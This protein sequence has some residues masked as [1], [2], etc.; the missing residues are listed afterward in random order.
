[1]L[2][3]MAIWAALCS[4]VGMAGEIVPA[5]LPAG[6]GVNIHFTDPRPGEMKMLAE[7]GFKFVR[8]DFDWIRTEKQKGVYDFSAYERLLAALDQHQIRALFILDY[9]SP[10]YDQN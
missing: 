2:Y 9:A 7:A 4:S 3:R 5:T 6:L 1:M 8:M 10:L